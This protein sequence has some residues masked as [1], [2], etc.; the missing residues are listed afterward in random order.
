MKVPNSWFEIKAP[1]LSQEMRKKNTL[2]RIGRRVL[3]MHTTSPPSREILSDL[4]LSLGEKTVKW[5][6]NFTSYS[7]SNNSNPW[8]QFDA[9]R[10]NLEACLIARWALWT[11]APGPFKLAS[12]KQGSRIAPAPGFPHGPRLQAYLC[13]HSLDLPQWM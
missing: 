11:L 13:D 12:T 8:H 7:S 4:E 1:R 9:C 2:K 3:S 5:E 6:S 10:H